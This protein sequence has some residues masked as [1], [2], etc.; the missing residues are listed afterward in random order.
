MFLLMGSSVMDVNIPRA[1]VSAGQ[2]DVKLTRAPSLSGERELLC[3]VQTDAGKDQH[4]ALFEQ[5][6]T[7]ACDLVVA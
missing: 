2:R 7:T 6:Q 5:V 4:A 3:V 1:L